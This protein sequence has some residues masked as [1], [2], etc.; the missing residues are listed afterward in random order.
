MAS[1]PLR[2]APYLP[3]TWALGGKNEKSVDLPITAVFLVLYIIGAAWHMTIFQ[4]NNKR[5]HKFLFSAVTFGFCMSRI[6]TCTLRIASLCLPTNINLGIAASIFVAAGVLILFIINLL[7]AQRI[8]RAYHP[9][10]GWHRAIS[11]TFK[12][13]YIIVGLT[14]VTVITATV[15]NFFTLR[16]DI[17]HIDRALQLYG[18][19]FLAVVSSLP[20][21]VVLSVFAIPR[22]NLLEK[23]GAGRMRYKIAVLLTGSL[24]LS[25]GAWYRCGTAWQTPV[26]RTQPLPGYMSKACFYIFNFG[27]EVLTVYLY[28][29]MRVDIRFHIPNGAKGPGSYTANTSAEKLD[30]EQGEASK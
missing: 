20:I 11:I 7:W 26:P 14:L 1:Q 9:T 6:A 18:A 12:T 23:F 10:I 24:L 5:G 30:E 15:Q 17:K 8:L 27:V 28:A 2:H 22:C 4:L 3:T 16:P 13:I 21:L 25:S 19:T 29:I